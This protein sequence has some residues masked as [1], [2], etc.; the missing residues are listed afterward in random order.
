MHAELVAGPNPRRSFDS[1]LK[2]S[3]D[4]LPTL[5]A[6]CSTPPGPVRSACPRRF[7]RGHLCASVAAARPSHLVARATRCEYYVAAPG[8]SVMV[9]GRW[10]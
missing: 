4:R 3:R 8:P 5:I 6:C 1:K 10:W 7:Y 9:R 2:V